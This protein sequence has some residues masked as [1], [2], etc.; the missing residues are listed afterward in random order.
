[1]AVLIEHGLLGS[2][3]PVK[4]TDDEQKSILSA[5]EQSFASCATTLVM[6]PAR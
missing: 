6:P 4:R 3:S 2:A 5:M 1:V